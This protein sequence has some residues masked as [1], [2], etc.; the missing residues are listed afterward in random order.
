MTSRGTAPSRSTV[1]GLAAAALVASAA[2]VVGAQELTLKRPPLTA[3]TVSCPALP[4]AAAPVQQ[5]IDEANRLATLGQEAALEGDHRTARNLFSQAAQLDPRDAR[6]AYRLGRENEDL[7]LKDD[8]V[9][10]Y[11]RYLTLA[12]SAS[13]AA[14]ISDRVARLL[15]AATVTRGGEI[16]RQFRAGLT[17]Y[18]TR[19]WAGAAAAF[20]QA[21]DAS[22]S[23][24]VAV[25]DR[26]LAYDADGNKAAATRDFSRYLQLAPQAPDAPAVRQR[27]DA[28]RRGIPSA[29]TAAALGILPGGGQF[30]TGQPVLGAAVIAVVAGGA[31]LAAQSRTV[32]RDTMFPGPFG[33]SY[34]GT[35]T[36]TQ[37]PNVGLGVGVAGGA[38]AFGIIEA[39]IVAHRRGAAMSSTDTTSIARSALLPHAGPVSVELPSVLRDGGGLRLAW[40]LRVDVR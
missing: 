29:T 26:G 2:R 21:V 5:Q 22:P 32:T 38:L 19:D 8:A 39:A 31:V 9:Q 15:P 27:I 40:G 23:L 18:D 10:Q 11:C 13:D 30:Y 28:L 6:L 1:R 16:V 17:H 3:V 24:A 12:P 25:Y 34:A 36:Q 33:G 35:Y 20:G 14:D 37:H 7:N 4:V